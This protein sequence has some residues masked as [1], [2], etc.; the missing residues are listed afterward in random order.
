MI[1][2]VGATGYHFVEG[3]SWFDGLYMTMITLST[4]GYGE[5]HPLSP[6]GRYFTLGLIV[7]G[8]IGAG[9]LISSLTQTLIETEISAALGRRRLYKDINKLRNHYILCG[10]GRVGNQIIDEFRRKGVEFVIIERQEQVAERLL[11]HGDLVLIGDAT[12][13]AVLEGAHVREARG[14]LA[15]AA[16]DAENVYIV[17]TARGMNPDIYIVARATEPSAEKKLIRAGANR[18]VSPVLI[19]SIA[20]PRPS[21]TGNADHRADNDDRKVDLT[22]QI[23]IAV[24]SPLDGCRLADAD[25]RPERM[26][27]VAINTQQGK[28]VFNPPGEQVL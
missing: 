4:I 15:S 24:G 12:D 9:F 2:I 7:I 14:L 22:E 18:V 10:A 13:E 19:G 21:L 23:R 17:L 28:M 26:M 6:H 5:T 25:F 20:W 11:S 16:T 27:L 8:V 1:I 3:W